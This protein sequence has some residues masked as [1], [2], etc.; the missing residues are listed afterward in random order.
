MIMPE[1]EIDYDKLAE[2]LLRNESFAFKVAG[3]AARSMKI[4]D[5][6]TKNKLEKFCADWRHKHETIVKNDLDVWFE[7]HIKHQMERQKERL[8][9]RVAEAVDSWLTHRLQDSAEHSTKEAIEQL[10]RDKFAGVEMTFT[11]G[12]LF[13]DRERDY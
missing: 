3:Y 12:D 5:G 9:E 11:I 4:N 1:Q 6:E 13:G 7:G 10:I 2:A 8:V